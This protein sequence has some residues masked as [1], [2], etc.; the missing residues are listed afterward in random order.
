VGNRGEWIL[1]S[2]REFSASSSMASTH[3]LQYRLTSTGRIFV[4]RHRLQS[5]G[6]DAVVGDSSAVLHIALHSG[7]ALIASTRVLHQ[8]GTRKK[9]SKGWPRIPISMAGGVFHIVDLPCHG[10]SLARLAVCSKD[11]THPRPRLI[12][13][14]A[15]RKDCLDSIVYVLS[16]L[17]KYS[18]A[19]AVKDQI[20][21]QQAS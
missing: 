15:A 18:C 5:A 12:Y 1:L 19:N 2:G 21:Q 10:G 4:R 13:T 17:V 14:T 9:S 3:L 7:R 11:D 8:H 20:N 6:L 16:Q